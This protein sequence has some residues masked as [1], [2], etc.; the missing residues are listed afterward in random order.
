ML[1]PVGRRV[2]GSEPTGPVGGPAPH[3]AD[4]VLDGGDRSQTAGQH[5]DQRGEVIAVP[6][7]VGVGRFRIRPSPHGGRWQYTAGSWMT[8]VAS[9]CPAP[10]RWVPCPSTTTSVRPRSRE[11]ISRRKPGGVTLTSCRRRHLEHPVLPAATLPGCRWTGTPFR[12][13]ASACGRCPMTPAWSS[14]GYRHRTLPSAAARLRRCSTM[15][16]ENTRS[17]WSRSSTTDDE[18]RPG[19]ADHEPVAQVHGQE[20]ATRAAPWPRPVE[21]RPGE[22]VGDRARAMGVLVTSTTVCATEC[23]SRSKQ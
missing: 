17:P 23:P 12:R 9:G 13:R 8:M 1:L 20:R 6:Q 5:P 22:H 16:A 18:A 19:F 3:Q 2:R 4:P 10:N 14:A 7:A 21:P 11:A 15:G